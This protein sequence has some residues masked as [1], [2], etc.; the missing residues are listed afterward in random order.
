MADANAMMGLGRLQSTPLGR[1]VF[2]PLVEDAEEAAGIAAH[3]QGEDTYRAR[4]EVM[5][6]AVAAAAGGLQ[7][8]FLH[9]LCEDEELAL[10]TEQKLRIDHLGIALDLNTMELLGGA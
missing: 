8:A 5:G 2:D 6:A 1:R 4:R 3:Y 10:T 9:F 7:A